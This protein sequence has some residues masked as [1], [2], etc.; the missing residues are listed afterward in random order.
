MALPVW[1]Y[2]VEGNFT[3][4]SEEV[5]FLTAPFDGF[6]DLLARTWAWLTAAGAEPR[7]AVTLGD[8]RYP[9]AL[10]ESGDPPLMFYVQGRIEL[11]GEPSIAVVGSRNPTPQG[12]SNAHSF[13]AA[14]RRAGL[15]VVSG[16]AL[17]VD[18]AAHEGALEGQGSTI[19]VVG[20]GATL[21]GLALL[22][23][24]ATPL[25]R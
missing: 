7:D 24:N 13:A 12:R 21:A 17:G 6:D 20:T 11:L 18:G 5:S 2:R 10:L 16:M 14:L 1:N 8:P 15:T 9:K 22:R 19:A 25:I 4:K 3:L 23:S